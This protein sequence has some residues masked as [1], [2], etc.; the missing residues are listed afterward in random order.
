MLAMLVV[1]TSL[2]SLGVTVAQLR[3]TQRNRFHVYHLPRLIRLPG[4][5]CD[6]DRNRWTLLVGGLV[7]AIGATTDL[8]ERI[9]GVYKLLQGL[10]VERIRVSTFDRVKL[11]LQ[12]P[13][14]SVSMFETF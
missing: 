1:T 7:K 9:E 3:R 10:F 12:N 4:V 2:S 5:H 13:A 6:L 14:D 11:S 8:V